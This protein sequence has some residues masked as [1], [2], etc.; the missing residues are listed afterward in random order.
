[1]VEGVVDLMSTAA[2]VAIV[3]LAALGL[4]IVDLV[5]R[6]LVGPRP[7]AVHYRSYGIV[8]TLAFVALVTLR[9]VTLGA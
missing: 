6:E 3:G 9:F 8:L 1:M 5:R 2:V 7:V 4:L